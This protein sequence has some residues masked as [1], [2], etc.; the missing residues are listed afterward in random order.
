MQFLANENFPLDVVEA[1]RKIGYAV[2]WVRTDT[3]LAPA[4]CIIE[5]AWTV[6]RPTCVAVAGSHPVTQT[7]AC[8][9]EYGSALDVGDQ[10]ER[11]QC[12]RKQITSKGSKLLAG[13]MRLWGPRLKLGELCSQLC[14]TL[15][16]FL[17]HSPAN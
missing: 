1:V 17:R 8:S 12:R 3:K 2:A 11:H 7:E 15:K 13:T 4:S 6:R 16:N 14:L 10:K 5:S 9:G